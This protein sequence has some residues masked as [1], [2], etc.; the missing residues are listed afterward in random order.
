MSQT[1]S[2]GI[3]AKL[4]GA[5]AFI[6]LIT[7]LLIIFT[8]LT[9]SNQKDDST[10]VNIA[11]RQRMLSQ[12]MSKDAMA[13]KAGVA[14]TESR[15]SLKDAHDLFQKSL[16]GL[17]NGNQTLGL[18]PTVDTQTLAQMRKVES[19]WNVFSN[20]IQILVNP[21]SSTD[22]INK[23]AKN[24]QKTNINLL[25]TMNKAVG[26]YAATSYKKITTLTTYL[27][28]GGAIT[29]IMTFLIWLLINQS[30]VKPLRAIL[31]MVKGMDNGDLDQRL[32]QKSGDEIGQLATRMDQFADSLK[33]EII[34]AFNH[35]ADGDFSFKAKGLISKPLTQ[36][37]QGI[38]DTLQMVL[39]SS[40]KIA[41]DTMQVSATSTSLADGATKQAAALEEISA[42][43]QEMN[44]QTIAVMPKQ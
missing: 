14:V 24:I 6:T 16:Q 8:T 29:I 21:N 33:N 18:P 28:I 39:Q 31:N 5:I 42:S 20:E 13:I 30:I 36:A 3:G 35:L 22:A 19:L 17:V 10:V 26:M 27:Y 11:G 4:T 41:S 43:M 7:I 34:S 1:T 38:S 2:I 25:T 9:L 12:K 44:E 23:A 15:D 40:Q 32:N 37:N